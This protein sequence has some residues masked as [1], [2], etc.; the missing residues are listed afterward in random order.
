MSLRG[1][2]GDHLNRLQSE[3]PFQ[4]DIKKKHFKK[5]LSDLQVGMIEGLAQIKSG[6]KR[7]PCTQLFLADILGR[8][9]R[10]HLSFSDNRD[11]TRKVFGLLAALQA[12]TA[13]FQQR[14]ETGRE[15][16]GRASNISQAPS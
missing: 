5:I 16:R 3:E 9:R 4:G 15:N 7:T 8:A 13:E 10:V 2:R 6:E 11:T 12:A 1:G 14:G